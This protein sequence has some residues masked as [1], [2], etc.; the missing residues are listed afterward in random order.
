MNSS[1]YWR[2]TVARGVYRTT[3]TVA[4]FLGV[5]PRTGADCPNCGKKVVIRRALKRARATIEDY[6]RWKRTRSDR[7]GG[8]EA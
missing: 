4:G 2:G 8:T 7:S 3:C 6:R 1:C 5:P